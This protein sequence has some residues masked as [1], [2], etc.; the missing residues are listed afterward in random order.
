MYYGQFETDKYIAD[1][2]P[3]GYKGWCV[4]VGAADG[5]KGSNTYHFE[6]RGWWCL[7][8]EPNPKYFA[9][10]SANR[11]IVEP[12]ACSNEN[13]NNVPFTV[14]EIGKGHILSSVSSLKVDERLR[15]DHAYI[16]HKTYTI[17]VK[18]RTLD[19]ILDIFEPPKLD[20]VSIDTEGTELGVLLGFDIKKWA[21]KLLVVENN[22]NDS[23]VEEYLKNF[24]YVKVLRH[25]INDF[26]RGES[27][28][29]NY[30]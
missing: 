10:L 6:K 29:T 26:Y 27:E 20:L 9:L 21:P 19:T 17:E 11:R 22:Y 16:T 28:A 1:F 25:E 14:F 13:K 4:D 5:I 2:F 18:V 30:L 15:K 7:C 8:I 24:G 3:G 12:V 23:Y